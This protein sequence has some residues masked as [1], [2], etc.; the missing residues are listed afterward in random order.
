MILTAA[1]V[2]ETIYV[3]AAHP[4]FLPKAFA[5]NVE[6]LGADRGRLDADSRWVSVGHPHASDVTMS[7][8]QSIEAVPGLGRGGGISYA[9]LAHFLVVQ[10]LLSR[11]RTIHNYMDFAKDM[12]PAA[13][14]ACRDRILTGRPDAEAPAA[15]P[16][17][18]P[19]TAEVALFSHAPSGG[20]LK[21]VPTGRP[22]LNPAKS[23]DDAWRAAEERFAQQS[24][25]PNIEKNKYNISPYNNETNAT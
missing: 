23:P 12:F 2:G 18:A 24:V 13:L 3:V 17:R 15:L 25:P 7:T 19:R 20:P 11:F 6:T 21:T 22:T 10:K 9:E 1:P 8:D 14:V 16:L 4:F 5:A